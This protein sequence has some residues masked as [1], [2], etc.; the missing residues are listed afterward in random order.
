VEALKE[1]VRV[2]VAGPPNAGKSSLINALS[3]S[4]RAIVTD[5]EGTT[6]D[7]IEVPLSIGGVP[8]VLVD[9]AGLRQSGEL[10]EQ[11]GIARAEAEVTQADI[12]LWLGEPAASPQ[13]A[14]LIHPRSDLPD[15]Q[16]APPRS[17]AVS[18][19]TKE[20]LDELVG[21]LTSSSRALLPADGEVAINRRQ[22]TEL[23]AAESALRES[24]AN[25]I[26][27]TAEA[28]RQA[29]GAFDRI[30]GTSG[31]EDMLDAL[32]GRFCLGK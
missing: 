28:L 32:F 3:Q 20:G 12:L 8:F 9:T 4:E 31:V 7:V 23:Q 1:G 24:D 6:R 15:R 30:T 29:R 14:I 2:V 16:L 18:T 26:L 19:V 13:G 11:L 5:V 25:E 27:L 17:L 22:T 10:V 21:R